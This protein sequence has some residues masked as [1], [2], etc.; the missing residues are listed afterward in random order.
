M[1][2]PKRYKFKKFE[3]DLRE[4]TRRSKNFEM[5][6]EVEKAKLS[7]AHKLAEL[8]EQMG[9]SQSELARKMGISQQLIS[10]IE[11]GSD[12]LTI[13]T[14]IRFF[15]ILGVRLKIDVLKRGSRQEILEF[16]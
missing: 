6:Y 9:L 8:R 1:K 2:T 12:N 16:I 3:P 4:E 5:A 10:R 15:D 14:L 13:E 11:S 7:M